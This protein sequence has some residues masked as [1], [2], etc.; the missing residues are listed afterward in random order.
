MKL[1]EMGDT[2]GSTLVF[3]CGDPERGAPYGY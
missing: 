2:A 1:N 3:P